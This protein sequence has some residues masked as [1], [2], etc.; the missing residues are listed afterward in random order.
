M[1][2]PFNQNETGIS[3]TALVLNPSANQPWSATVQIDPL[4]KQL[5]TAINTFNQ[6]FSHARIF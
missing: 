3:P 6:G 5:R 4:R 1:T 2:Q